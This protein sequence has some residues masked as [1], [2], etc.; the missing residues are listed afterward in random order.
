MENSL[1]LYGVQAWKILVSIGF[2]LGIFEIFVPGFVLLPIGIACITTA[3]FSLF[4][5][6]WTALLVILAVNIICV[7]LIFHMFIR[8]KLKK[9]TLNTGASGMVGK[10]VTVI[11]DISPEQSVYVKLYGD[12]WMAI[13][14]EGVSF[15]KGEKAIIES[16]DGNKVHIQKVNNI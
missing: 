15:Q 13:P 9:Q 1:L 6:S 10:E 2:V 11:Q 16:V 14:R 4:I 5:S 12:E 3:I 8:P 7:L